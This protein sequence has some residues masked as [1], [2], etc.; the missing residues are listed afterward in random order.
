MI[1]IMKWMEYL[2]MLINYFK[3]LLNNHLNQFLN[4]QKVGEL[5]FF[6]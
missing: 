6:N 4:P 2:I 1:N 3:Y 5:N